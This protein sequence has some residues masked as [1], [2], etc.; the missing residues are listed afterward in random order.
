[1]LR[2]K[3]CCL[4]MHEYPVSLSLGICLV[5]DDYPFRFYL[6]CFLWCVHLAIFSKVHLGSGTSR[7]TSGT[8][9][10]TPR[11]WVGDSVP[12]RG[13]IWNAAS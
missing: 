1:M 11:V 3:K 6:T 10:Q 4:T 2:V 7:I 13:Y 12:F 9:T 5:G 8:S